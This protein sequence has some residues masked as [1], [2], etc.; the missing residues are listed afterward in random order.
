MAHPTILGLALTPTLLTF[1]RLTPL[2]STTASL[3]HAY[4]ELVTTSSFLSDAPTTSSLSKAMLRGD[5]PTTTPK[6]TDEV[7]KA[8]EIVAPVWF[9]N[10]FN[11]GVWSVIGFNSITLVSAGVNLWMVGLRDSKAYYV[12]GLGAA[13][14]HYLFVPLVGPSIERLF[15]MCAAQEKGEVALRDGKRRKSAVEHVGEWVSMHKIRMGTVDLVAW[16]SFVVGFT[17]CVVVM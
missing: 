1:M 7:A 16:M 9:V 12:T 17:K 8:K 4:M 6:N 10:F 14:A 5:E 11:K 13:A 15:Q 3:T 2:L